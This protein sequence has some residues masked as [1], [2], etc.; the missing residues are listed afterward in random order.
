MKWV[1]LLL[2][3]VAYALLVPGLTEPVLSVSGTVDKADLVELGREIIQPERQPARLRR[4]SGRSRDRGAWTSTGSVA[5]FDKTQSILGTA[6]ELHENG[7]TP[8]AMLIVLFSV[9]V[10][11]LK[12]L[13]LGLALC[14]ARPRAGAAASSAVADASGKWSMADVFVIAIFIAYLAAGGIRGSGGLVEFESSLGTG[15]WYFL[16]YCL[17]SVLGTQL[18][19]RA[20]HRELDGS[21]AAET[22]RR[23][24]RTARRR[25]TLP[26]PER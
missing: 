23:L 14:P 24:A 12:A 3:L 7:D 2:L 5:A 26:G 21:R 4:R 13:V 10:P 22:H 8:V 19:A 6:R 11:A 9:I 25:L 18:L 17:V 1:G 20:L 15:F 16:G